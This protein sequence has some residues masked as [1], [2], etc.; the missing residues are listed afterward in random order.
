M[1]RLSAK[2]ER[3]ALC[4]CA[5]R[6]AC[7]IPRHADLL[8]RDRLTAKEEQAHSGALL[9]AAATSECQ[10]RVGRAVPHAKRAELARDRP[11][12]C[13][14]LTA[15]VGAVEVVW[16]GGWL[17]CRALLDGLAGRQGLQEDA[18]RLDIARYRRKVSLAGLDGSHGLASLLRLFVS[19]PF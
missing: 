19:F 4:A 10:G 16:A 12:C 7:G 17:R 15:L 8:H 5:R 9:H 2:D 11:G 1:R 13:G 18:R 6:L 14:R 3:M